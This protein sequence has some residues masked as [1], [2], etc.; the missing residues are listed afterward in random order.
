MAHIFY[1]CDRE[2]CPECNPDCNYTSNIEHAVNFKLFSRFTDQDSKAY[3][4]KEDEE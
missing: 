1:I 4:E 3:F 2:A